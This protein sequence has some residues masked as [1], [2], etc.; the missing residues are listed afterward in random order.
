MEI[1]MKRNKEWKERWM[2]GGIGTK[3]R[4]KAG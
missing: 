4:E 1:K 3:E 2:N